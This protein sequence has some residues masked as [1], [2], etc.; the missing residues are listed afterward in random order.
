MSLGAI[1]NEIHVRV[2]KSFGYSDTTA[3]RV[4]K[5]GDKRNV[6]SCFMCLEN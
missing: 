6:F 1:C 5:S 4:Q 3:Q 2:G